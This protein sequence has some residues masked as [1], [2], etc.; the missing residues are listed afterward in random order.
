MKRQSGC[1]QKDSSRV[2]TVSITFDTLQQTLLKISVGRLDVHS[3]RSKCLWKFELCRRSCVCQGC[4]GSM[5]KGCPRLS[6]DPKTANPELFRALPRFYGGNWH[7]ACA[8]LTSKVPS[9]RNCLK[10]IY[11]GVV[12]RLSGASPAIEVMSQAQFVFL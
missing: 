2:G 4:F 5:A 7:I 10:K 12:G 3:E 11:L 8:I 6:W 1:P 9:P